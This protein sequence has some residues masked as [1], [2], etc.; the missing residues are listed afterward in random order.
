MLFRGEGGGL[1]LQQHVDF[2]ESGSG[3]GG[4]ADGLEGISGSGMNS[5]LSVGGN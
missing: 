3:G 5:W 1:L 2:H 4:L